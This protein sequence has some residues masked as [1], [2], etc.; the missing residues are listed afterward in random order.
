MVD[1]G[2]DVRLGEWLLELDVENVGDEAYADHL[3]A[4]N[5][6]TRQ[7]ILEMGRNVQLG[8][9]YGF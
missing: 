2:L 1:L 6:F 8:F 3:N 7:R 9:R 4:P 5:P